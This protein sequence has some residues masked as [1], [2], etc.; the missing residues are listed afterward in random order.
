MFNIFSLL[1]ILGFAIGL[2]VSPAFAESPDEQA[3][4][5]MDSAQIAE[6]EA[7]GAALAGEN[8]PGDRTNDEVRN[9]SLSESGCRSQIHCAADPDRARRV[10][11]ALLATMGSRET[12]PSE[13]IGLPRTDR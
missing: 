2:A 6:A 9:I 8:T 5:Q 1:G 7:F 4:P 3:P 10:L 11:G 13:G 12:R